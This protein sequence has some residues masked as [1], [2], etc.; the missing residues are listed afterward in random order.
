M[1]KKSFFAVLFTSWIFGISLICLFP[2]IPDY[3]APDQNSGYL[4]QDAFP[5]IHQRNVSQTVIIELGFGFDFFNS[6]VEYKGDHDLRFIFGI[7]SQSP[8]TEI[9][10][11]FNTWILFEAF[12]ETW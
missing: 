1:N 12:F 8:F 6:L 11:F 7:D 9:P 10:T 2:P 4:S 5:E 3:H